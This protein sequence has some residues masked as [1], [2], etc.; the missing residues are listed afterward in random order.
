MVRRSDVD[1]ARELLEE[2]KYAEHIPAE[3]VAAEDVD[4]FMLNLDRLPAGGHDL[5]ARQASPL[6]VHGSALAERIRCET[7]VRPV[8]LPFVPYNVPDIED[9]DAAARARSRQVLGLT[10]DVFHV[11][12]FGIVDSRT[13]GSDLVVGALAWLR[14]WGRPVHLHV[15]GDA[16]TEE[17]ALLERL[18]AEFGIA[19]D[20]TVHGHVTSAA[21]K[22]F[23]LAV[24]AAVQIRTSTVLSLSGAL[25]DCIAFGLPTVTTQD[26][27][28]EM[29]AP[30]YVVTTGPATSSLLIAEA[31]D[32]LCERRRLE[33]AGIEAERRAYLADRTVDAYAR[34]LLAALGLWSE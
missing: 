33:A 1:D 29:G 16:P 19:S 17:L 31:L 14:S 30:P 12:T 34:G 32:E 25:A 23:L 18:A 28:D 22:D 10:D 7:G 9:V 21:L 4:D 15:V 27:A 6:I 20:K 3:E 5:I 8:V 13:K 24:D 11:G 26:V 2:A